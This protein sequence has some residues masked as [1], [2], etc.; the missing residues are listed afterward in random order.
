MLYILHHAHKPMACLEKPNYMTTASYQRASLFCLCWS[1]KRANKAFKGQV[2]ILTTILLSLYSQPRT[3]L[4]NFMLAVAL[5][6]M[7]QDD[8]VPVFL[9]YNG[10]GGGAEKN[11]ACYFIQQ[12]PRSSAISCRIIAF[13]NTWIKLH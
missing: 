7:S 2:S 10:G 4:K 8:E 5:T 12:I 3:W 6:K 1:A 11:W 13:L 9:Q